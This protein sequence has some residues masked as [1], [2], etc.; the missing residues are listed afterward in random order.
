MY[1]ISLVFWRMGELGILLSIFTDLYAYIIHFGLR[2]Y[3][4]CRMQSYFWQQRYS[5]FLETTYVPFIP[6]RSSYFQKL[7]DLGHKIITKMQRVIF[8]H[9]EIQLFLDNLSFSY[10]IEVNT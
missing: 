5:I 9:K 7:I 4:K 6:F 8:G 10:S 2:D 1:K 3:K